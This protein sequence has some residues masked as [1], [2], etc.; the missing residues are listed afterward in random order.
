MDGPPDDKFG[1]EEAGLALLQR[2]TDFSRL[3]E[4]AIV[5]Y[6]TNIAACKM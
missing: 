3:N 4:S 2:I 6:S 5:Q 1:C